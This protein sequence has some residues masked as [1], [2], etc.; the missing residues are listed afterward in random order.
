MHKT[1]SSAL[2]ADDEWVD[3]GWM[4]GRVECVIS[5]FTIKWLQVIFAHIYLLP[6]ER[7]EEEESLRPSQSMMD[8]D[9]VRV[10]EWPFGIHDTEIE[11]RT[12]NIC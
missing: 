12:R 3:E 4:V 7:E 5:C 10:A 11:E 1:D 6:E 9:K 8:D 2:V